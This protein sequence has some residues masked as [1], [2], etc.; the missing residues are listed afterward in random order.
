MPF[1]RRSSKPQISRQES[2]TAYPLLNRLV[3]I[4]EADDGTVLL[5]VPRKLTGMNRLVIQ[6]FRLPSYRRIE[7]DKLG[8][9][10]LKLCD[11]EHTVKD[12][13]GRLRAEFHL[14]AR[15]AEVSIVQ[16]LKMLAQR[17]IIGLAVRTE[18]SGGPDDTEKPEPAPSSKRRRGS[19]WK[20][21]KR[22]R[23]KK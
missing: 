4:E 16:Y 23:R 19:S 8:S 12:I 2:L 10:V 3:K 13:V 14:S 5:H 18:P 20:Q 7:L 21:R 1:W 17:G 9:F 22:H 15:E 11:G 6:L